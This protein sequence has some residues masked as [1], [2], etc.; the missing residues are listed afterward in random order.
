MD[1]FPIGAIIAL[2]SPALLVAITPRRWMPVSVM[3]WLFSPVFVFLM[4]D[5]IGKMIGTLEPPQLGE[6]FYALLLVGS[7]FLIP[8]IIMSLTGFAIGFAIR[9]HVRRTAEPAIASAGAG[10]ATKARALEGPIPATRP[11]QPIMDGVSV[12]WALRYQ[13]RQGG[14]INGRYD[15]VSL[16]AILIDAATGQVLVDCA[17]WASSE[18]TAQADG[19]LFLHLEQNQFESLFRI[20]GRSGQFRDL[21]AGGEDEPLAALSYA[22]RKAWLATAPHVSPSHYRHIS[23]DGTIRVDLALEEWSNANWVNTPR[24]IEIATGRV[25]LDLWG[26]DWDVVVFFREDGRTRLTCRRCHVGVGLSVVLDVARG[27]YQITLDSSSGGTLPEQ[28]LDDLAKGLEAASRRAARVA[29]AEDRTIPIQPHLLAAWRVALLI[30]VGAAILIAGASYVSVRLAAKPAQ[31]TR[32][33]PVPMSAIG[34]QHLLS[35]SRAIEL[36]P[37]HTIIS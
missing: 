26:T 29:G 31:W 24:V 3:L 5:L 8:W 6:P 28:P 34:D 7:F 32:I 36:L 2:A 13:H 22:V 21:G 1:M 15:S 23:P 30:L 27:C 17:S 19:S 14:F 9:Q 25:V 16:C 33:P 37:T 4:L 20:D 10:R 11:V 12:D 35:A 18:I